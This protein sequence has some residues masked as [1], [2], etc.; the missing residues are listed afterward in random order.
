M[1]VKELKEKLNQFPDNLIVMIPNENLYRLAKPVWAVPAL[2]VT[3]GCNEADGCLFIDNYVEEDEELEIV[4]ENSCFGC[5]YEDADGS[6]TDI[7]N[8]VSCIRNVD[9]AK[10]DNY[11][12]K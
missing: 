3:R 7:S 12:K 6:T 11:K 8:C 1:T 9:F 4:E 2:N 5:A 10:N